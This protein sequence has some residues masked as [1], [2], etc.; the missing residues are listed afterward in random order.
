M[1]V[2]AGTPKGIV[3]RLNG[4]VRKSL[5]DPETRDKLLALG[6]LLRGSS[7]EELGTATKEKFELY[8]KVIQENNIKAD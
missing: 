8:R 1:V 3:D 7:P 6:V 4:E 5:A 2:P